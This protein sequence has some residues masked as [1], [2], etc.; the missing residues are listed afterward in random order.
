MITSISV[1][2][3]ALSLTWPLA[4]RLGW[5]CQSTRVNGRRNEFGHGTKPASLSSMNCVLALDYRG[6]QIVNYVI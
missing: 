5:R 6:I 2:G 1:A 3:F 4:R